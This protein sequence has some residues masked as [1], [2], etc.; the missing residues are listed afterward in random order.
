MGGSTL[1]DDWDWGGVEDAVAT[2]AVVVS[3]FLAM[4]RLDD[5]DDDDDSHNAD[6]VV[7]EVDCIE[8]YWAPIVNFVQTNAIKLLVLLQMQM[9]HQVF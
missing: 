3:A 6:V 5:D 8:L 9:H 1:V 2:I 4:L 7:L